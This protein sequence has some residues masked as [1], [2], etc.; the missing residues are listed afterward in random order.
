[1]GTENL[2]LNSSPCTPGPAQGFW[3]RSWLGSLGV[4]VPGWAAAGR[5]PGASGTGREEPML[6]GLQDSCEG[7]QDHLGLFETLHTGL[8]SNRRW[9][10]VAQWKRGEGRACETQE[11]WVSSCAG[12][13]K[14]RSAPVQGEVLAAVG[15][16]EVGGRF[17]WLSVVVVRR[18]REPEPL[19]ALH[20]S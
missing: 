14:S 4:S 1:M 8:T 15:A 9:G 3:N 18:Q 7:T 12:R 13:R 16:G 20:R 17:C 5:K 19:R 11:E 6:A 2:P 10:P